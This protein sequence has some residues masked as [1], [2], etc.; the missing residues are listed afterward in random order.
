MQIEDAAALAPEIQLQALLSDLSPEDFTVGTIIVG[1][2][3][4]LEALSG[5]LKETD[6]DVIEAYFKWKAIQS[7]AYYIESDSVKPYKRFRNELSGKVTIHLQSPY[8]SAL[9][10]TYG[11]F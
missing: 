10:L 3:K 11:F 8:Y 9:L 5:I 6:K 1:S 7:L 2:P 4:Y